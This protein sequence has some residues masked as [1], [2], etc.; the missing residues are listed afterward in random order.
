MDRAELDRTLSS[1]L[2]DIKTQY[3]IILD[4]LHLALLYRPSPPL[5][6]CPG[7]ALHAACV[8]RS[9]T[10]KKSNYSNMSWS[11]TCILCASSLSVI[12]LLRRDSGPGPHARDRGKIIIW[13]SAHHSHFAF[14]CSPTYA[15]YQLPPALSENRFLGIG[16]QYSEK[17]NGKFS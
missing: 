14:S 16:A 2:M 5:L 7:P 3:E 15:L 9:L 13:L 6:L 1:I 12:C 11:C 10:F 17:S 4:Y 8:Q